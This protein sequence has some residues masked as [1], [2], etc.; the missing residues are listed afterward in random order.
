[1]HKEIKDPW[2]SLLRD[3]DEA[4]TEPVEVHLLGGFVLSVLWDLP[5]PTGDIDFI[6]IRPGKASETVL[7]LA[8]QG[9][10]LA[11]KYRVH[12]QRVG[13]AIVPDEYE[14]RLTDITPTALRNLRLKALDPHDI[15]LSK[16][17]RNTPSDGSDVEFLAR[18]GVLDPA[19]LK[20]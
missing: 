9:T 18:K 6:E 13:V 1:M 14:S 8:G 3:L 7:G 19:I 2:L 15:V 12:F 20:T 10:A 17:S 4:L 5:R 16:L 11:D